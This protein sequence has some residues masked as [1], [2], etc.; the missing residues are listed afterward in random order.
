MF[1]F[2][3]CQLLRNCLTFIT[4]TACSLFNFTFIQILI[5]YKFSCHIIINNDTEFSCHY[6]Q[7][8]QHKENPLLVLGPGFSMSWAAKWINCW[9]QVPNKT[10]SI[11]RSGTVALLGPWD[12]NFITRWEQKRTE[13]EKK[14]SNITAKKNHTDMEKSGG[15]NKGNSYFTV[16][17][18]CMLWQS[19]TDKQ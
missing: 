2:L 19:F 15:H 18:Y 10:W 8:W 16:M 6:H 17:P 14:Q 12:C 13:T 3:P 4:V 5:S 11:F 1:P 9:P 7:Y